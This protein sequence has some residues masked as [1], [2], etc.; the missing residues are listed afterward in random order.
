MAWSGIGTFLVLLCMEIVNQLYRK[1]RGIPQE[2]FRLILDQDIILDYE[3]GG[4]YN[5]SKR[6]GHGGHDAEFGTPVSL[7]IESENRVPRMGLSEIF[8][9]PH[10]EGITATV[11]TSS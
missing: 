10:L 8:M 1:I 9:T 6:G 2:P 3:I 4:E 11:R 5:L 7:D